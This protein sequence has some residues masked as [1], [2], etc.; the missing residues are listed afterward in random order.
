M[1]S[2]STKVAAGRLVSFYCLY[3]RGWGRAA[4]AR[5]GRCRP[6]TGRSRPCRELWS[7]RA[8]AVGRVE[9]PHRLLLPRPSQRSLALSL[10]LLS[11][12]RS[13]ESPPPT[14][15]AS[16][17]LLQRIQSRAAEKEEASVPARHPP[18]HWTRARERERRCCSLRRRQ[19]HRR[20]SP[21]TVFSCSR[22]PV[23]RPPTPGLGPLFWLQGCGCWGE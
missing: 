22:S 20:F 9:T 13:G 10:R 4:L 17:R 11:L 15:R 8:G 19:G 2:E 23:R 7:W 12:A 3:H 6:C 14:R 18:L 1:V 5:R 16:Q 21:A